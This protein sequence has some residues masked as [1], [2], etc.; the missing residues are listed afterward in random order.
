MK[1]LIQNGTVVTASDTFAADVLIED[2]MIALLGTKIDVKA[3]KTIDARGKFVI[4]GGIDVHT[5]LDMPFGGS[6]SADDFET[7]T[8]AAAFGGTTS[9]VDFAIQYKGQS[10]HHAWEA[11]MGKAEGKAAIDYGFHMIITD[12]TE[13]AEAEM[14]ALVKEGVTSFKLFMAYPGVFMLDDA[15]IFRALLR[16]GENG[17]TICMHAENGGVI[18]VLV[19]RALAR[20]ETA[21]KYHALTR[22]PR[23]EA[24]ATHR[25]I[26]L[27]EM[28]DV[29]IYIVHLSAAEALEMVTEARD[30]GL[31][32]Y[33][34]TCPQYLFLSYD[35]YEE[36]GFAGAKYVMSPPLR[37]KAKQAQLWRGLAGNDLQVISTDHC[38]FC[39]KEQK[40][41][42]KNDFSKIP[43]GAPGIE[44]RMSLV[45]DGGVREKRI[46]MNRFVELTATAPAKIFGMWPKRGTIAPGSFADVVVFDA[47]REITLAAK[48]LHMNVDYNPYEGRKVRGAPDVVLSRGRVVIEN[49][50]FVGKVGAG[51]FIKRAE[52]MK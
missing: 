4:P 42:G 23:A 34:E 7:G 24:E 47:N 50:K 20:G 31:P 28:A 36:P 17:G 30:R 9:V 3:D 29:P 27:A 52:R 16:T 51:Q 25:A 2:E 21:P 37:D 41:L 11:W 15:T 35:N 10:L 26:A 12:L 33:A 6:K 18:D 14:D 38:P 32:A 22:P 13:K 46:S 39:M 43:N 48:T 40:E 45:W 5:H 8:I 44:T 1:T 19:K 49:G